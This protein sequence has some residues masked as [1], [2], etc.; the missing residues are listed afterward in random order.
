MPPSCRRLPGGCG[1]QVA[2]ER[3]AYSS[4][5]A[6]HSP[7]GSPAGSVYLGSA[8]GGFRCLPQL[9]QPDSIVYSFGMGTDISF[10]LALIEQR[11]VHVHSF[12]NSPVSNAW[13]Q[14]LVA[15]GYQQSAS[16]RASRPGVTEAQGRLL[17]TQLTRHPLLLGANNGEVKL[18]LPK[19][20]KTSFAAES[21]GARGFRGKAWA[22]QA[23]TLTEVRR[24]LNHSSRPIDLLKIDV[25]GAEFDVIEAWQRMP[26]V[27]V[28]QL[29]IE[30]HSRL[31]A[32]GR[33]A[34]ARAMQQ[35]AALGFHLVHEDYQ[36][37]FEGD[38]ALLINPRACPHVFPADG[39][40]S[41]GASKRTQDLTPARCGALLAGDVLSSMW[42][43]PPAIRVPNKLRKGRYHEVRRKGAEPACWEHEGPRFF[44][45]V[46]DGADCGNTSWFDFVTRADQEASGTRQPMPALIGFLDDCA[47]VCTAAAGHAITHRSREGRATV[48][49]EYKRLAMACESANYHVL[50]LWRTSSK[51]WSMC[52][53]FKWLVCAA[54]GRL[55][56][57]RR[58]DLVLASAPTTLLSLRHDVAH[59]TDAQSFSGNLVYHHE[60]LLLAYICD[61]GAD[62]LRIN[63]KGAFQCAFNRTRY[64][65]LAQ[66]LKGTRP[67]TRGLY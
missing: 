11:G 34:R 13:W 44:E 49:P 36:K 2:R 38:N 66:E 57:Q 43:Q 17:R 55:P 19:G 61:N 65:R 40:R 58:N 20:F 10:D 21:A 31:V 50:M 25:E 23:R 16:P 30:F 64:D 5:S 45:R 42:G 12:D 9:L 37:A 53:N 7:A 47:K 54:K 59:M 28:C 48:V 15:A 62:L 4:D 18:R 32:D 67:G 24:L 27:P 22:A 26:G 8:Y 33:A 63:T 6:G 60:V 14:Q 39:E 35:L 41:G 51:P 52:T 56:N 3:A 46:R 1:G 29:A